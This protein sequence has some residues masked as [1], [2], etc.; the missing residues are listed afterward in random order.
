MLSRKYY[1][2]VSLVGLIVS[3][4]Q[5]TKT[6]VVGDFRL[7]ES[8]SVIENFLNITLVHNRGAAFG[9]LANLPASI[10]EPFFLIIPFITLLAILIAFYKL[11]ENEILSIV[12]LVLIVGGAIGNLIDRVRI[13]YVI[14]F[15]DFHWFGEHHFPAFNVADSAICIG[16]FILILNL[17]FMPPEDI[18]DDSNNGSSKSPSGV[19]T[20]EG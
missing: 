5:L 4:D 14:D 15:I 6:M 20:R 1:I 17:T 3:A 18:V 19:Y 10:R 13:G 16:V 8:M 2:L 11:T 9:L 12:G 7:H